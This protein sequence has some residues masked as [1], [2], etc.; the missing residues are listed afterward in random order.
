[1]RMNR[2][3][4]GRTVYYYCSLVPFI[5]VA[6]VVA[7]KG[8][9]LVFFPEFTDYFLG[10]VIFLLLLGLVFFNATLSGVIEL[11]NGT[12]SDGKAKL[13]VVSLAAQFIGAIV[14]AY[15]LFDLP[16]LFS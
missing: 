7:T 11:A 13:P 16:A 4:V 5:L 8:L 6:A 10:G 3:E 1:M 9:H 2:A 12:P 14:L 15:L